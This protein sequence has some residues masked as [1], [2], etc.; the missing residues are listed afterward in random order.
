LRIIV[1]VRAIE[2]PT[3]G[4]AD[5]WRVIQNVDQDRQPFSPRTVAEI[6]EPGL[7]ARPPTRSSTVT[8]LG[9]D[10]KQVHLENLVMG[11]V[12]GHLGA[13]VDVVPGGP[14]PAAGPR[15]SRRRA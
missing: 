9:L 11:T 15:P 2:V 3:P 14:P 4:H 6:V 1:D 5:A 10:G 12:G 8:A 7:L 13:Y